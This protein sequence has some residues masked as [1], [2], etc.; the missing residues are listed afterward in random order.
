MK[1]FTLILVLISCLALNFLN[2]ATATAK[3]IL[4]IDSYNFAY[5]WSAGITAGIKK[6][7]NRENDI[8]LKIF[9]MDTKRHPSLEAKLAAA[10]KARKIIE[11]WHPDV[12]IASDDNAS[13]Y[14]IVPYYKNTK[15]PFVFCG[16]NWDASVYGF[17]CSNVTG[18]VEVKLV[19]QIVNTMKMFARGNRI[20][21]L[22]GDDLSA[23]REAVAI[24]KKYNIHLDKRF[25]KN[26]AEW[27]HEYKR[28]Q[29]DSDMI[30]LG[31]PVSVAGWDANKAQALI[32]SVTKIPSGNWDAWMAPYNL[33]TYASPPEEQGEWAARAALSILAGKSPHDIPIAVNK[34]AKI[35]LN[36]AIAKNLGIK[37]PLQL[38]QNAHLVTSVHKK[39]LYVNSYHKGYAWSDGIERGLLNA[40]DI[41]ANDDGT[42]D[43]DRSEV[44][45]KIFRMDTKLNKSKEFKKQAAKSAYLLID[46]W[47]PDV[48]VS[49]DDNAAKYLLVPY[50]KKSSI[51]FVYCG[52]NGSSKGYGLPTKNSTGIVEVTP[53]RETMALLK[54]YAKGERIGYIGSQNLSSRRNVVNYPKQFGIK[55]TEGKLVES[56][57]EWQDEYVRLQHSVDILLWLNPIG[58]KGWDDKTAMDFILANTIIPTGGTSDNNVRYALLGRVKIAEEQGWWAG[59]AALKIINGTAPA[60]IPPTTNKNS[61]LYLNMRLAKRMGIKFPVELIDQ[62]TFIGEGDK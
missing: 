26:F 54:K 31:A 42:F 10:Q 55:F 22:K 49:S 5:P 32:R 52:I 51:P 29:D 12:V 1:N 40:L 50:M 7:L 39:L 24:E 2:P 37:F 56:F 20:S 43:T 14:L 9:R 33:V 25:V 34:K 46:E 48:V 4:Y 59:K 30:L 62:A 45:I 47:Q 36:M 15:L 28:L 53:G 6:V 19:D 17:P 21:F 61:C 23:R 41:T 8:D 57:L 18:M 13:K 11:S 27:Q 58:I 44:K 60:D 16:I 3:K 38:V 35:Y